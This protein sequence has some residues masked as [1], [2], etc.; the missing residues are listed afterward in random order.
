MKRRVVTAMGLIAAGAM[1]CAGNAM[2][3][4]TAALARAPQGVGISVGQGS[5]DLFAGQNLG[6]QAGNGGV[7]LRAGGLNLSVGGQRK[8]ATALGTTTPSLRTAGGGVNLTAG[9]G[10]GIS[11]SNGGVDLRA[12]GVNLTVGSTSSARFSAA[13]ARGGGGMPHAT[14][15]LHTR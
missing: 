3:A 9:N 7:D 5:V 13:V 10:V 8:V 15:V 6:I 1:L 12:G 11:A 2:A 4:E 14:A